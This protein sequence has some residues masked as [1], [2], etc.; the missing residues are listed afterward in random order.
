[1]C[2]GV[3]YYCHFSLRNALSGSDSHIHA[4]IDALY[5]CKKDDD[6]F[7]CHFFFST[8]CGANKLLLLT[9][10]ND[11]LILHQLDP[12]GLL[13]NITIYH[14]PRLINHKHYCLYCRCV[15]KEGCLYHHKPITFLLDNKLRFPCAGQL[16]FKPVTL[17]W[18][19]N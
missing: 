7:T 10:Y 1:M 2:G 4:H 15:E 8:L 9:H 5:S 17:H 3:V 6:A 12:T 14:G 11:H 13:I 18:V 19:D 16:L